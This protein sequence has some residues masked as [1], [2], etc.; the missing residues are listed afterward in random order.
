MNENINRILDHARELGCSDVHISVGEGITFRKNGTLGKYPKEFK[1][2][3]LLEMILEIASDNVNLINDGKDV[4]FAYRVNA[5]RY[6]VNV[7]RQMGKLTAALRVINDD[8]KTLEELGLPAR[9]TK[10]CDAPRGLVLV[11]G[12]TGSGKSTT[13]AAM[14][15]YINANKRC[16]ILTIEDP[17]EYVY[18]K[19]QALVHQREIGIDVPDLNM[20]LK[21]ALREDPDIVLVG[22]M[23]DYE[24]I[25]AVLTLAETGHLVFSTLHTV[26][27]AKTIDR[28]INVFPPHS[29]EQIRTQL[30]SVLNAVITQQLIPTSDGEGRVAALEIMIMT[31]AISNII[32]EN[33]LHLIKSSMQTGRELG[34]TTLNASLVNL[35]R[36]RKITFEN[37]YSFTNDEKELKEIL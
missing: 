21:S 26:G 25:N 9:L 10:L 30:A 31:D 4:D 6:R 16:H 34:M 5:N 27:T 32:R 36:T 37:A 24:T 28:I 3:E 17:V 2:S 22:E 35:V 14:I 12:P 8:I 11:T 13:L 33:K 18:Q 1:D 29:Q 20:A 15:D 23:R 19:K 7:Y